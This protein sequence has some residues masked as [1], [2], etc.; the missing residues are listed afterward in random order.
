MDLLI[1][2]GNTRIK[3][4]M[5]DDGLLQ[6]SDAIEHRMGS[7]AITTMLER[8][9]V[10]PSGIVAA[11]VAGDR[12]GALI[13]AAVREHWKLP[14]CFAT[15]QP[16][17]GTVRNG[18]DDFRQLGV[19][20]WLAIIAAADRF[21]GPVCIVDAG[22]AIT[23]DVVADGGNHLGGY[24]IPGLDLM[25]R[26]LGEETGDLRQLAGDERPAGRMT[27]GH[28]TAEAIAGG[29]LAAVCSLIDRCIG[30]LRG[31]NATPE[32]VI[33]GGDAERLIPYFDVTTHL[34]P[35]LV[36]EGLA[37]YATDQPAA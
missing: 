20:R 30:E 19:D 2:I 22:T 9:T 21:A 1:D 11:N 27:P 28:G 36:L 31:G 33:T 32:L 12:I 5:L 37:K 34:R 10:V 18:Y 14:V 17:A 16:Q 23:I 8:I 3:W 26:S 4:A 25:R 15:S 35:Q 13:S 6:D 24:I 29:S 7:A